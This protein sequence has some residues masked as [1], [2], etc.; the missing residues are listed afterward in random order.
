M[1]FKIKLVFTEQ[2]KIEFLI[3]NILFKDQEIWMW[4][5]KFM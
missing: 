1:K 2:S 5:Q 4:I 3:F